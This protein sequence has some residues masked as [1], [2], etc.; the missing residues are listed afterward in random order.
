MLTDT[1]IRQAKSQEK[2]YRLYDTDGIY[3]EVM[4]TGS[5]RWRVKYRFEGRE[6]R[7]SLGIYPAVSL[8]EARTRASEIRAQAGQ[9]IDPA[10]AKKAVREEH[11]TSGNSFS[12][13]AEEFYRMNARVWSETHAKTVRKRLDRYILPK[14]GNRHLSEITPPDILEFIRKLEE[15][16]VHETAA[17]V[18][19]I[20]SMIF[21]LAVATGKIQG[22]PCRDLQ[23]ALAPVQVRHHAAITTREGA[24]LLIR[25]IDSYMGTATVRA[26]VMFTALTFVR[27]QELRFAKWE[28]IRWEEGL[29]LIPAERMKGKREHLVPLSRQAV[30]ILKDLLPVTGNKPF[31]FMGERG[32]RPIS[33]NTVLYA[34][35]GMGFSNDQM[36]AHGF[37]SMA[38]TLLNE[39]EFRSDVI[40]RQLA[41]VEGNSVRSAYNRA[42]YINE[43]RVMMQAWADFLDS[44]K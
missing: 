34:L 29:W 17:R 6:R 11:A 39:M 24:R 16:G 10:E 26:A 32:Q 7:M 40:E 21:R 30:K 9:G 4:P 13:V 20:C 36:T 8:K 15:R 23:G 37:R 27:Q 5:K 41:H 1:R 31:I 43:R 18:M 33:E 44:L 14:I 38:S 19:G 35:R 3:L 42:E 12:D 25:A 28:E 2:M 22:D